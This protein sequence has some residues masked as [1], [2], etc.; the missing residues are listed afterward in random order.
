VI[1]RES[2][3]HERAPLSIS[4]LLKERGSTHG[5]S[6]KTVPWPWGPPP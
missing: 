1:V 4:K 2:V 6:L 5:V 3:G